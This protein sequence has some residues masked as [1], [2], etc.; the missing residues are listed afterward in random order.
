MS[1]EALHHTIFSID[2]QNSGA[3]DNAG[4]LTMREILRTGVGQALAFAGITGGYR[5]ED[6]GDGVLGTLDASVPKV[7]LVGAFAEGLDRALRA[8]AGQL[9]LQLRLGVHGGEIH[10]DGTGIAGSD[11]DF[12]CRIAD[13][14]VVKR[15]LAAA[16]AARLAVVVSEP[17]YESVVRHGGR[18]VHPAAYRR[19]VVR[20]KDVEATAWLR[21]PGYS[22]PPRTATAEP[23][24]APSAPACAPAPAPDP[25]GPGNRQVTFHGKGAYVERSTVHNMHV[26]DN[27]G[28]EDR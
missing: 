3:L 24:T 21:L 15:A 23:V 19:V 28:A 20:N 1:D 11:I 26:G 14:P 13:A 27:R 12:A 10:H 2:A 6:R 25:A 18:Y 9:A 5:L 4:K 17:V 16:H 7:R 8:A 22:E